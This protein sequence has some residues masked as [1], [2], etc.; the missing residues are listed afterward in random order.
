VT[1]DYLAHVPGRDHI[2]QRLTEIW[3][4]ERYT[5]PH[6]YGGRYFYTRNDGLQNQ[7]ILYVADTLDAKPRV[8]LDPNTL[9]KDGTV[10]LK[11]FT[12]SED[13][14]HLAYG[15]SSGGRIGKTGACS[16]STPERTPTTT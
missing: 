13:G 11:A 15:L 2:K 16:M 8:L 1:F 9:S 3:N 7:A 14:K 5:S 6:Q 10:A 4:Y 12:I